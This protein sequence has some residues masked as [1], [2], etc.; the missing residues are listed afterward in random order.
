M[1]EDDKTTTT[2]VDNVRTRPAH[3]YDNV[4]RK[5]LRL[6]E[7]SIAPLVSPV[8]NNKLTYNRAQASRWPWAPSSG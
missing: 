6:G 4:T 1:S 5:L 8:N 2:T 7:S 3:V